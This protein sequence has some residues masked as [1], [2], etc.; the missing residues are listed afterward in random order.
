MVYKWW[1][2]KNSPYDRLLPNDYDDGVESPRQ[3]GRND[4]EFLSSARYLAN[5]LEQSPETPA[6]GLTSL[7]TFFGQFVMH[8]LAKT[9]V[10]YGDCANKECDTTDRNCFNIPVPTDDADLTGQCIKLTRATDIRYIFKCDEI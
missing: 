3:H 7:A 9:S 8:D 6:S 10:D 1:G 5:L 4:L 2:S